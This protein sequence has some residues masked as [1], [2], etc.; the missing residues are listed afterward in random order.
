[1]SF[2][3]LAVGD[4]TKPSLCLFFPC[5]EILHIYLGNPIS[6]Q[7][8]DRE[9]VTPLEALDAPNPILSQHEN[10]QID[11]RVDVG[12]EVEAIVV[13]VQEDEAVRR[14]EV[15]DALYEVVLETQQP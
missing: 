13:E 6:M 2:L 12:D 1:M 5:L 14:L 7:I 11:E 3:P 10:P 4:I 9:P 8:E 15:L